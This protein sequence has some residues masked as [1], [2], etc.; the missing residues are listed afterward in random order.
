MSNTPTTTTDQNFE[1]FN[2]YYLSL[3]LNIQME[4][5]EESGQH[6]EQIKRLKKADNYFETLQDVVLRKAF[7]LQ[8]L[9]GK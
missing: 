7:Y 5:V 4:V 9:S 8:E 2:Y 1:S 6:Q 3:D